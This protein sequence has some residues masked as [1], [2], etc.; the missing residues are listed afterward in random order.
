[1]IIIRTNKW[2][3]IN[4]ETLKKEELINILKYAYFMSMVV[5][6]I[7]ARKV[8]LNKAGGLIPEFY[9]YLVEALEKGEQIDLSKDPEN[10]ILSDIYQ[11][12]IVPDV[13]ER[14]LTYADFFIGVSTKEI[15]PDHD[16]FEKIVLCDII[17]YR[18]DR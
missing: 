14:N 5:A 8:G 16:D 6:P 11:N 9:Q 7:N 17:I 10:D 3:G 4:M 1:M 15:T 13:G 2:K 12:C 18:S